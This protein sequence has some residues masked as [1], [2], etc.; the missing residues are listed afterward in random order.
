MSTK[1]IQKPTIRSMREI[2]EFYASQVH[3]NQFESD[4][5]GLYTAVDY[6][7]SKK[8]KQIRPTLVLMACDLFSG[9]LE[10][11]VNPAFGIEV[12]HNS[13]LVHDDIMDD[14]GLRRGHPSV[15]TVFGVN[16]AILAGDVMM[17]FTS[18]Y[19]METE[20][21][22][23][24]PIVRL[25]NK[26]AIE[27]FEGQQLDMCFEKRN[28]VSIDE[29]LQMIRNKTAVLLAASLQIGA[30]TGNA[31]LADQNAIYQFGLNLGIAFQ[32]QDDFLDVFGDQQKFGKKIGG[33]I[34]NDKKTYLSISAKEH[35]SVSQQN[36][37]NDMVLT[38]NKE[39]KIKGFLSLYEEMGIKEK[40]E[41]II[42]DYHQL[43]MDSLDR[44]K[45]SDERKEPFRNL[46]KMLFHRE[47]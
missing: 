21:K 3:Q 40:T 31:S 41:R 10:H 44:I 26:T 25:F 6:I 33:D 43:S 16:N 1:I 9:R 24:L 36:R 45:V 8:G 11:A 29:Y 19:L 34:I 35:A 39:E 14:A 22:Y 18:K 32:L 7:L 47:C 2:R 23:V 30:I 42:C 15:H 5:P 17:F 28:N 27:V 4:P 20:E 37:I 38:A 13:T 46:V 12:F